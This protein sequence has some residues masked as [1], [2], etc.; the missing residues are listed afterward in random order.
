MDKARVKFTLEQA[1][2]IQ[3]GSRDIYLLSFNLGTRLWW[4]INVTLR[5][6]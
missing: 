6:L 3:S 4:V 2:K 5:S 1:M